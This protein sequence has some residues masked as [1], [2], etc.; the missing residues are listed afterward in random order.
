M[1]KCKEWHLEADK[2]ILYS[3]GQV[4]GAV[5]R[6]VVWNGSQEDKDGKE[7]SLPIRGEDDALDAQELGHGP[8]G[9]KIGGHAHPEHGEGVQT[10][11]DADVVDHAAPE[12]A[13]SPSYVSFLVC[14]G[15]LH[16][17]GRHRQKG[18]DPRVLQDSTFDGEEGVWVGYVD[19]GADEVERPRVG[20]GRAAG[21]EDDEGAFAADEVD[22]QLE[23]GVD[24]EGLSHASVIVARGR[25]CM[26][27]V[28]V[29]EGLHVGRCNRRHQ[30]GP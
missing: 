4:I 15:S 13:R 6:Y 7:E 25:D 1:G 26:Y 3:S 22:K 5:A 24:G 17:D 2:S 30:A 23:E 21:H 16:D 14:T 20:Y 10:D 28:N 11:R 9:L 18:L 8:E 29:S 19:L 12:V 27:L